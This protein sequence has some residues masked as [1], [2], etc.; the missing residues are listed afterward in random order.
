SSKCNATL[1]SAR[2]GRSDA[3]CNKGLTSP[4]A[5]ALTLRAPSSEPVQVMSVGAVYD[6]AAFLGSRK[7]ARSKT[8]PTAD[9]LLLGQAPRR[10]TPDHGLQPLHSVAERLNHPTASSSPW[11]NNRPV[12][13][14]CSLYQ[15]EC[16]L[17]ETHRPNFDLSGGNPHCTGDEA[18]RRSARK[19]P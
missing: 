10:R 3:S 6:R 14:S 7:Y 12:R 2:P 15:P 5:V 9:S 19:Q 1:D 4:E 13:R 11:R 8:A 17:C 16:S 18:L